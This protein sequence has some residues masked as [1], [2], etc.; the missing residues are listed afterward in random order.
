MK[1]ILHSAALL[2]MTASVVWAA[3]ISPHPV[4]E[5]C[6]REWEKAYEKKQYPDANNK[7]NSLTDDIFFM[8]HL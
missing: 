6:S 7:D 2:S 8:N 4:H 5:K 3:V 1:K